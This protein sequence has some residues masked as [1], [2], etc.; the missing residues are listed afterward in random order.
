MK[1]ETQKNRYFLSLNSKTGNEVVVY[2]TAYD[3]KTDALLYPE[4]TP[5]ALIFKYLDK[6]C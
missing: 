2:F 1:V 6:N 3:S 4:S 5:G